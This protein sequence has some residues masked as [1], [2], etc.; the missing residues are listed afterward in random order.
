MKL[1]AKAK[2]RNIKQKELGAAVQINAYSVREEQ[3]PQIRDAANALLDRR[4][5]DFIGTD[6]HRPSHRPPRIAEGVA[7][8]EETVP[9]GYARQICVT[10]ARER[11]IPS[12]RSD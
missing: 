11:L 4:L 10:N 7:A 9:P 5:A 1:K 2:E 6:A 3:D 8:I 12:Q